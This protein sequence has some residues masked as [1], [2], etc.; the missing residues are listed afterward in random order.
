[1]ILPLIKLTSFFFKTAQIAMLSLSNL[2]ARNHTS[3]AKRIAS[4]PACHSATSI[5]PVLLHRLLIPTKNSPFECL[6]TTRIPTS[7]SPLPTT[8]S[9]FTLKVLS[10]GAIQR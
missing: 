2:I 9:K 4:N 10:R 5:L 8:A 1:M 3:I 6:T 7:D